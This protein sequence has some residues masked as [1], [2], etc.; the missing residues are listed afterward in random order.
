MPDQPFGS[1]EKPDKSLQDLLLE[2]H[3]DLE[4]DLPPFSRADPRTQV[5]VP[6]PS[7]PAE[8]GSP[9]SLEELGRVWGLSPIEV[10]LVLARDRGAG[11]EEMEHLEQEKKNEDVDAALA[12]AFGQPRR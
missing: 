4:T 3:P 12:E 5:T 7:G 1:I 2:R 6:T 9:D 10:L 11:P 8:Y